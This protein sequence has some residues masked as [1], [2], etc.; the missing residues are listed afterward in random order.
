MSDK[1]RLR[2]VIT[3]TRKGCLTCRNRRKRC[4]EGRPACTACVRLNLKCTY[5]SPLKWAA[6]RTAFIGSDDQHVLQSCGATIDFASP[7]VGSSTHVQLRQVLGNI[8]I[9]QE[10]ERTIFLLLSEKDREILLQCE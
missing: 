5:G 6:D 10:L 8:G 4:D 3:R 9:S 7:H 2:R 1:G